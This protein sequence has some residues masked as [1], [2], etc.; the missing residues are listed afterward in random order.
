MNFRFYDRAFTTTLVVVWGFMFAALVGA[1][2]YL[3]GG[4]LIYTLDDPYIHL[5]LARNILNGGYGINM[6]EASSPSSS[7]IWPWMMA[8][9]ELLSLGFAGP[10]LLNI[11]AAVGIIYFSA[12]LLK[13]IGLIDP[14]NAPAFAFALAILTFFATSLFALPMTGMEHSWHVLLAIVALDGL[15]AASK[16]ERPSVLFQASI[17]LMPLIRFEGAAFSGAIIVSLWLLGY[18]RAAVVTAGLLTAALG[19]YAM[20]MSHLGLPVL[21][22]SVLLKSVVMSAALGR[23]GV[24]SSISG[25]LERSVSS[26]QGLILILLCLALSVFAILQRKQEGKLAVY[27]PVIAAILAH[28]MFGAVGSFYRYEV[29]I[30]SVALFAL[31]YAMSALPRP[32]AK[33]GI[34]LIKFAALSVCVIV[35]NSYVVAAYLSPF[36]SQNIYEQQFQMRRFALDFYK[37][38]VAVNDLGLVSYGNDNYVLD[39]WGLGSEKVRRFRTSGNYGLQQIRQLTEDYRVGLVM[40]YEPWYA[41]RMPRSWRKVAVLHTPQLTALMPDVS[42]FVTPDGDRAAVLDALKKLNAVLPP[43]DSL[44]FT[45]Y[46]TS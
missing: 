2:L 4:K 45:D 29:Y 30:L 35:A 10:L 34:L 5:A 46:P 26:E 8:L 42:F 41:G 27:L 44:E 24:L 17:V 40:I 38:P 15:I 18:C 25:T 19:T 23:G 11:A 21:P 13:R 9:T 33:D 20:F 12:R 28:L 32:A 6:G 14:K 16:G 39:L 1:S 22:S 3:C 37:R 43:Q 7:I 31:L 36:A